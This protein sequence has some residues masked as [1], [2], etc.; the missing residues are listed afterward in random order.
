[1]RIMVMVRNQWPENLTNFSV[2]KNIGSWMR[3]IIRR[4]FNSDWTFVNT[5]HNLEWCRSWWVGNL[6]VEVVSHDARMHALRATCQDWKHDRMIPSPE[7]E[8]GFLA[9]WWIGMMIM[10]TGFITHRGPMTHSHGE[11]SQLKP[12]LRIQT[13]PLVLVHPWNLRLPN[14]LRCQASLFSEWNSHLLT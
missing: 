11:L 1:M 4:G 5:N 13:A 2:G 7:E 3:L 6:L 9:D 8:I 10:T 14:Q 12:Q